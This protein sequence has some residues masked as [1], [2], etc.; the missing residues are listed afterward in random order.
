ME[1]GKAVF[2]DGPSASRL[3]WPL[4]IDQIDYKGLYRV[5]CNKIGSCSA[6]AAPPTITVHPERVMNGNHLGKIFAAAGFEVLP[7][8]SKGGLDDAVIKE[9]IV[10]LDAD[11]VKEIVIVTADKDFIPVLRQKAKSGIRVFWASTLMTDPQKG[12]HSLSRDVT[13][14]FSSGVFSFVELSKFTEDLTLRRMQT[15]AV[16]KAICMPG[17][18][19]V[20]IIT[21]TLDSHDRAEHL[22]FASEVVNLQARFP[23]L[24][25]KI[26]A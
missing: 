4:G 9:R 16:S 13:E 10:G 22:R 3:R 15:S 23:R 14:L 25:F 1:R 18:S 24:K 7:V 2:V 11:K 17:T 26:E 6:L 12:R 19:N 8:E 5:L 21:L 20:T